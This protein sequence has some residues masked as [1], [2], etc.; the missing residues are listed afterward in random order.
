MPPQPELENPAEIRVLVTAFA[1]EEQ[2]AEV[3]RSLVREQLVACGSLLRG[4][5]SIYVWEG[6][7]EDT[8]EIVVL[9][10]TTIA[11]A[12]RAVD[13]LKTLH[14]YD[15]PEILVLPAESANAAYT[16]W[17]AEIVTI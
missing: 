13:R 7:L 6:N 10:K 14:P 4:A 17:M 1:K 5:R 8:E 12:N 15:V 3:V 2:A 11:A 9:L 16:K